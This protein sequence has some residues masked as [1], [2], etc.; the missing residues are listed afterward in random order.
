MLLG[1][2]LGSRSETSW[3]KLDFD[4]VEGRVFS[5]MIGRIPALDTAI[6]GA[7]D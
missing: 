7:R 3:R 2:L 6:F 1:K 5:Y 4:V